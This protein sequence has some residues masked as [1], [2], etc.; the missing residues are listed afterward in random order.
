MG[1]FPLR[2]AS[3]EPCSPLNSRFSLWLRS[4][5]AGLDAMLR[6]SPDICLKMIDFA[7]P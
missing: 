1:R 2:G 3:A 5:A 7:R 4:G 6:F